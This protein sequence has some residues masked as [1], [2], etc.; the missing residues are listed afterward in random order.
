VTASF[1]SEDFVIA[2]FHFQD[3]VIASFHSK[4]FVI[5]SFHSNDFV[6]FSYHSE[7][8]VIVFFEAN[9]SEADSD[10]SVLQSVPNAVPHIQ[11]GQNSFCCH[12]HP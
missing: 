7:D 5:A 12:S 2:S 10:L 8:F 9:P 4:D 3:F 11:D 1:P 6:I